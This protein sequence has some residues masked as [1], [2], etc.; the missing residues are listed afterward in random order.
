M[1]TY[2]FRCHHPITWEQKLKIN[3]LL[4]QFYFYTHNFFYI[5]QFKNKILLNILHENIFI[6]TIRYWGRSL[7]CS[8]VSDPENPKNLQKVSKS[9]SQRFPVLI[10]DNLKVRLITFGNQNKLVFLLYS[11]F[12]FYHI[13]FGNQ[14]KLY[15]YHFWKS[16]YII[17]ILGHFWKYE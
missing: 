8:K 2:V 16:E 6:T 1:F 11:M 3:I 14:N 4:L 7:S 17:P 5:Q 15:P 13:T 10:Y 9:P 12:Y